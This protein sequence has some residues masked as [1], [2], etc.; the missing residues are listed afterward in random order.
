L[1]L[2]FDSVNSVKNYRRD[3]NLDTAITHVSYAADD[4][5][6]RRE[7]FSSPV[8]QVIVIHVTADKPGQISFDAAM[9]TPQQASVV[10]EDGDTLVMRGVNGSAQGI[11]G[12]LKFE[13]RVRV[14]AQGGKTAVKSNTVSVTAAESVTLLIAAATSYRSYK[15]V[16][17]DP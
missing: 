1:W 11:P 7:A 6:Y 14:V 15:D 4:V 12:A 10:V 8:D 5:T 3:L 9:E 2:K 16:G 17:G 13:G